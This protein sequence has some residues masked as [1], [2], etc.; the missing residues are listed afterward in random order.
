MGRPDAARGDARGAR[1]ARAPGQGPL[2]RRLELR[3]LAAD[4]GA[5]RL[6]PARLR[7]ASSASRSTTRCRR[8]RPSTSSCRSPLDQG[9]RH[10]RLEPARRRPAVGQV[11]PRQRGP[12]GLA[13]AHRTGASRRSTTRTQLYDVVD[14]LVEIGE[15]RGVSAAQVALAWL[16]DAAR[17]QLGD[18]RRA[19]RR[20]ARRQPRGRRA[21]AGRDEVA[22]LEEVSRPP[23]IYPHWHQAKTASDRLSA[24]DLALLGPHVAG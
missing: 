2:R 11:P 8:A 18:H 12:G 20:A 6:R 1:L 15:A 21:R 17:G 24:G 14:V 23:L 13:P 10:P 9:R 19:D 22:R 4:E 3:R 5:R 7:S 16:L